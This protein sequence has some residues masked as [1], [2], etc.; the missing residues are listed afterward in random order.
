MS[1]GSFS[2]SR[3]EDNDGKLYQI[4]VQPE[5]VAAVIDGD[6]NGPEAGSVT[7][8]FAAE[9]NRGARAYGLRPRKLTVSF[10][11]TPPTGYRPY[12]TLQIPVLK[13]ETWLRAKVGAVVTYAGGTGEIKSK[14][15]ENFRPGESAY[16][17]GDEAPTTP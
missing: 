16:G 3:Y 11:D 2:L 17:G 7:E 15:D 14:A 5:I 13:K 12:T 1:A 6:D 9:V 10:E 4:R 8:K